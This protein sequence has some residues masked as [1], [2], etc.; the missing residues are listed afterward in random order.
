MSLNFENLFS[1]IIEFCF[2]S[3]KSLNLYF[4]INKITQLNLLLIY[5]Y[6]LLLFFIHMQLDSNS[7]IILP[8]NPN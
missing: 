3:V 7:F 4:D 5:K 1:K 8:I 2:I 6:T